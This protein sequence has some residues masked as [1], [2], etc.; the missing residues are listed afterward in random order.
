MKYNIKSLDELASFKNNNV[1]YYFMENYGVTF[2]EG[3]E[4]FEETKK[5]LWLCATSKSIQV[6]GGKAPVLFIDNPIII[7]DEMWHTFILFTREYRNFCLDYFGQIVEHIPTIKAGRDFYNER[8]KID[9]EKVQEERKALTERQYN[10]VYDHLGEETL[11]TWYRKFPEKYSIDQI[12]ELR[13]SKS[14]FMK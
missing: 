7:I 4:I 6:N 12:D 11:L 5:W 9:L 2:D 13:L 10:F 3:N 1:I 14:Q 8:L